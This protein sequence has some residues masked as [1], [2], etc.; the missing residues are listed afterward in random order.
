MLYFTDP[1]GDE[2]PGHL[3][4]KAKKQHGDSIRDLI[5]RKCDQ[6]NQQ[7]ESVG[8]LH[9]ETPDPDTKPI[10]TIRQFGT[11]RPHHP[12][13]RRL[14]FLGT[15]FKRIRNR[16]EASNSQALQQYHEATASWQAQKSAFDKQEA[17]RRAIIER[18]IHSNL[19]A[20]EFFLEE[21]L[22]QIVWPRETIVSTAILNDGRLVFID[23]D[24]PEIEDMPNRTAAAPSRGYKLS[25]K[26]MSAIQRQRLYMRHVHGI[27]FRTIGE[28]F[29]ALPVAESV[30]LSGFSQRTD[31]ATGRVN[32]EYLY[33][34]HVP[35]RLWSTIDFGNLP[36]MDVVES[37]T[38]FQIRRS[39]S[40]TG[41]FKPITPFLPSE[42]GCDQTLNT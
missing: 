3:V 18:G 19:P 11:E 14:G 7:I 38:R 12:A 23:V 42:F 8:E 25:V 10:Y 30:V 41:S 26:E 33:S 5:Q 35:R 32:D 36:E 16:I 2:L 1:S 29:A 9:F 17:K 27:A 24:L 4:A 15:L 40:K 21:S 39:M 31:K 37:L 6:I 34:V 28:T 13:L 22:Q 20:M